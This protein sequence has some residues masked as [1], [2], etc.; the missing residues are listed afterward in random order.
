MLKAQARAK[1]Y[2]DQARFFREFEVK[3]MVFLKA[4]PKKSQLRLGKRYKFSLRYYGP[5][6]ILRKV[7]R[8]AYELKLPNDWRIHNVFH[9]SLLRKCCDRLRGG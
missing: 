3:Y 5:F 6:Q 9:A 1:T 8:V 7:G 2:D 4:T